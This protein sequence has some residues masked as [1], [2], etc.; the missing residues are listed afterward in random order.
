MGGGVF[1]VEERDG[2]EFDPTIAEFLDIDNGRE[3]QFFLEVKF[4][5]GLEHPFEVRDI[6]EVRGEDLFEDDA[7]V[8]RSAGE[9]DDTGREV[10]VRAEGEGI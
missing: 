9:G 10:I 7:R 2:E 3:I 5:A 6:R 1:A 8:L 4:Q